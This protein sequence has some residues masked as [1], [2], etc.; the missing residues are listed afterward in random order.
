MTQRPITIAIVGRPN[1]GKSS[2]FNRI[3]GRRTS[4]VSEEE[5]VTRDRLYETIDFFG[6]TLRIIDTGGIDNREEIPFAVLVK[7]Q[8]LIAIEEADVIVMVVDGVVGPTVQ[9]KEI[10]NYLLKSGRPLVLAINKMDT[11]R[12]LVNVHDFYELGIEQM[13]GISAFHG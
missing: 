12:D 11:I 3:V 13:V 6:Q 10:A 9:D 1:V 5:G 2:L 4:I 8:A 7:N